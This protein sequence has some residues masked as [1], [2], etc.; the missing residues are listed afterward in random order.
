MY[1]SYWKPNDGRESN[2]LTDH[3]ALHRDEATHKG[4]QSD[5]AELRPLDLETIMSSKAA[6]KFWYLHRPKT[7]AYVHKNA[8]KIQSLGRAYA[9]RKLKERYG[10]EYVAELARQDQ[11]RRDADA[12]KD[13]TPEERAAK[14]LND[15][16]YDARVEES[17]RLRRE[18]IER[19]RRAEEEVR[20]K[21]AAEASERRRI[22][23]E[24]KAAELAAK[25]EA[26]RIAEE[27]RLRKEKETAEERKRQEEEAAR[28][29]ELRIIEEEERRIAEEEEAKRKADEARLAAEEAARL[30]EEEAIRAEEERIRKEEE[31]RFA[32]EE[33]A[34]IAE[35]ER[36]AE[37]RRLREEEEERLRL[38]EEE[39]RAEEERIR[40]EEVEVAFLAAQA[41]E[42]E[43]RKVR[44]AEE[45]RLREE[46]ER[47]AQ[48]ER[49][50]RERKLA[51]AALAAKLAQEEAE[52]IR[53]ER[54]QKEKNEKYEQS[55]SKDVPVLVR[56]RGPGRVVSYDKELETYD[57]KLDNAMGGMQITVPSDDVNLDDDR[58]LSPRTKV[59]TPF[60]VGEV[61]GLDPHVGCYA[62]NTKVD[63]PDDDQ[64]LAFVQ[65]K[66]V[67]VYVEEEEE[68]AIVED[69]SLPS[70]SLC[71]RLMKENGMKR[72][73]I[74]ELPH[75]HVV[76]NFSQKTIGERA[77]K[78]NLFLNAAVKAE[79]LQWGIRVDDQIAVYKRRNKRATQP[80]SQP[81]VL[82]DLTCCSFECNCCRLDATWTCARIALA[83]ATT[84]A[85]V[86]PNLTKA[87]VLIPY[88]VL[89]MEENPCCLRAWQWAGYHKQRFAYEPSTASCGSLIQT[90]KALVCNT[91]STVRPPGMGKS[92][93]SFAFASSL[94]RTDWDVVCNWSTELIAADGVARGH[95]HST[96]CYQGAKTFKMSS[97]SRRSCPRRHAS[98][99]SDDS[100]SESEGYSSPGL[101]NAR[102]IKDS[103]QSRLFRNRKEAKAA[104]PPCKSKKRATDDSPA[105]AATNA[106]NKRKRQRSGVV[107]TGKGLGVICTYPGCTKPVMYTQSFSVHMET[108]HLRGINESY[109]QEHRT[110]YERAIDVPRILEDAEQMR[111]V[112]TFR[113]SNMEQGLDRLVDRF[114]NELDAKLDI[115]L[116]VLAPMF[117]SMYRW[118]ARRLDTLMDEVIPRCSRSPRRSRRRHRRSRRYKTPDA[119]AAKDASELSPSTATTT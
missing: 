92:C 68:R 100:Y 42:E 3:E 105:A 79:H 36:L 104:R 6:V 16:A 34:R 59:D 62:I 32:A 15:A 27:E 8:T 70:T 5:E 97:R 21:Q 94:D 50:E 56:Q 37:E 67:A 10:A 87:E 22:E 81:V 72:R 119:R 93:P 17:R 28:L 115:K 85:T 61:V 29:E 114:D 25:L 110:R 48:A 54:I 99:D 44:E 107:L 84:H 116:A 57:I 60:G 33:A 103:I 13:L 46:E 73:D 51:E 4:L 80:S 18:Q 65:I 64:F 58:I 86:L 45:A 38:E 77:E 20:M 69:A 88:P 112:L 108:M 102:Y 31:E 89:V 113:I 91:Y 52:R 1:S 26:E 118:I 30:A 41:S 111:K 74:P 53:L 11:A 71:D 109:E 23:E 96:I 43:E 101:M 9:V 12:L 19:E 83:I 7:M 98:S 2:V 47:W 14:E 40:S 90:L 78:L 24:R 82:F 55:L 106:P 95:N 49:E 35:E 75:R 117:S 66:D 63:A 39:R 76:G